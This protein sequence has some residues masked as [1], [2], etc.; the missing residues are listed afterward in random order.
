V[1]V[2]FSAFYGISPSSVST[3]S[4]EAGNT[5]FWQ[6]YRQLLMMQTLGFDV[7]VVIFANHCF[8]LLNLF[9]FL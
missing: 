4:V 2:K 6:F 3:I 5:E 8:R 1:Q 7:K 9:T